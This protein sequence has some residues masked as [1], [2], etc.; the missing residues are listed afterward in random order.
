[1]VLL[2]RYKLKL[3]CPKC[4]KDYLFTDDMLF[5]YRNS[6]RWPGGGRL[7]KIPEKLYCEDCG[8]IDFKFSNSVL[9]IKLANDWKFKN[10]FT[11]LILLLIIFLII[12]LIIIYV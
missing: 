11:I 1:M 3:D 5:V 2:M 9:P 12:S 6:F 10:I 7:Y 8:S 4:N